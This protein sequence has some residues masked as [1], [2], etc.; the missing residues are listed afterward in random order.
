[1]AFV[2]HILK[3]VL[4]VICNQHYRYDDWKSIEKFKVKENGPSMQHPQKDFD[5]DPTSTV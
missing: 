1:M 3:A 2:E 5:S 4:R